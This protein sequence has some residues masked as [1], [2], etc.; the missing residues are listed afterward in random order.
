MILN[1]YVDHLVSKNYSPL[2]KNLARKCGMSYKGRLYSYARLYLSLI[3]FQTNILH[4]LVI[5]R[6]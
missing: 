1:G 5:L 6:M 3:M 2:F 4:L